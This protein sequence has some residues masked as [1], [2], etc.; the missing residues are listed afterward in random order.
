[1]SQGIA[2]QFVENL[3][4]VTSPR[5]KLPKNLEANRNVLNFALPEGHSHGDS[6]GISLTLK[7]NQSN[8]TKTLPDSHAAHAR[9]AKQRKHHKQQ[10][11]K[12]AA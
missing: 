5:K 12:Q 11:V 2:I 10:T 6:E 7:N 4:L 1:M 8:E 3:Q 9:H